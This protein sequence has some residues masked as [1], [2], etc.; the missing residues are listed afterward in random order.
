[1]KINMFE[2]ARR[3]TKLIAVIWGL[4]WCYNLAFEVN[5]SS[6]TVD[7]YFQVDSPGSTPTKMDE[8]KCD[9]DDAKEYFYSKYTSKGTRFSG[10]LCFKSKVFDN[11][12]RL[13]PI[14]TSETPWQPPA[15][16]LSFKDWKA[17]KAQST[18]QAPVRRDLL[19]ELAAKKGKQPQDLLEEF[20][21]VKKE[22]EGTPILTQAKKEQVRGFEEYSTEV[23][24]Y[25]KKV[26]DNFKPSKDDE[27]WIDEELWPT[28]LEK[29][30]ESSLWIIG[31][32]AFLYIFSWCI[33]WIIR[34]FAGI[35]PGQDR[36]PDDK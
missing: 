10:A 35:P 19:A 11:G 20:K 32:V 30:K 17:Q 34:G 33:G 9:M 12:K 28:R 31:G 36:K 6:P 24:N 13:I 16:A 7:V 2:G 27:A 4:G 23:S 29:I 21:K 5:W 26:A 25:T 15:G 18:Q 22:Q 14:Y 8:Q 1:M 3:L